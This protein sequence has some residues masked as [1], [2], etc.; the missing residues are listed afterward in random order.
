MVYWNS[1]TAPVA[2][3]SFKET[4]QKRKTNPNKKQIYIYILK[5]KK[6]DNPRTETNK[7]LQNIV[8]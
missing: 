1:G 2:K 8:H 5:K 4:V 7:N 3:N 6:K